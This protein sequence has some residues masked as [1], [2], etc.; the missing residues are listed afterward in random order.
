[1]NDDSIGPPEEAGVPPSPPS[2]PARRSPAGAIL[3]GFALIAVLAG[4]AWFALR[5]KPAAAPTP[6]AADLSTATDTVQIIQPPSKSPPADITGAD[7]PGFETAGLTKNQLRWLYH[8]ARLEE[9]GC[10]CG[11]NVAECRI[12]DPNCP[13]SPGRAV[14]LVAEA[15]K[16]KA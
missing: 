13:R 12:N 9:C 14:E 8:R 4:G 2:P 7:L 6:A 1:M 15:R 10:G 16:Q 5:L 3:F 11:W